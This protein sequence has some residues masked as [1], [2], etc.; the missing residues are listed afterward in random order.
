M[1]R[2]NV[3]EEK[4]IERMKNQLSD[5]QRLKLADFTIENDNNTMVLPQIIKVHNQLIK[6]NQ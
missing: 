1:L 2:D 3:S 6:E 4:V 5:E